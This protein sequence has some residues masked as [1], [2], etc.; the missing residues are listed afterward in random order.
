ML[1]TLI[2][3]RV[4]VDKLW[5]FVFQNQWERQYFTLSDVSLNMPSKWKRQQQRTEYDVTLTNTLTIITVASEVFSFP[6]PC[7]PDGGKVQWCN[8]N[9]HHHQHNNHHFS[10]FIF[11]LF[12]YSF[13][14]LE[15]G[16]HCVLHF[17]LTWFLLRLLV[18]HGSNHEPMFLF[19]HLTLV[20][21]SRNALDC[22]HE[23]VDVIGGDIAFSFSDQLYQM[24][25][26]LKLCK[27]CSAHFSSGFRYF[28]VV[29]GI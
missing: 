12:I 15:C 10:S 23:S 24:C 7:Q 9:Q 22:L 14:F 25:R 2:K 18:G 16:F 3:S 29:S 6:F 28:L 26:W 4:I 20:F 1:T 5:L 17:S 19:G 27:F 13:L 21:Y 8:M 11:H